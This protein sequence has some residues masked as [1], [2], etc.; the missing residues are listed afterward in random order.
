MFSFWIYICSQCFCIPFQGLPCHLYFD[1][2]YNKK[3]NPDK[4]GDE[5]VELLISVVLKVLNDKY[6]IQG[7]TEWIVELDSSTEGM[8]S[9][10]LEFLNCG[11]TVQR[12]A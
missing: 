11:I 8:L 10:F 7:N 2:E 1:L 12:Y 5:M 3:E 6:S 9:V 4:A